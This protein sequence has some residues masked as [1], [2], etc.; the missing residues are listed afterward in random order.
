MKLFHFLLLTLSVSVTFLSHAQEAPY[1]EFVPNF[2]PDTNVV[3]EAEQ[4]VPVAPGLDT[5]LQA[6]YSPTPTTTF[7]ALS[8][9]GT[10]WPPDV[11]GAVGITNLMVM[12]NSETKITDRTGA[13]NLLQTSTFRWWTNSGSIQFVTDPRV[14]YDQYHG[15]WIAACVSDAELTNSA[16]MVAVSQNSDPSGGWYFR[17]ILMNTTFDE[18]HLVWADYTTLGFNK[19]WIAVGVNMATNWTTTVTNTDGSTNTFRT[20]SSVPQRTQAG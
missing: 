7:Q 9:N 1:I 11:H 13:T 18:M 12:H 14:V 10:F 6:F 4:P 19:T 8:D 20:N 2:E 3:V 16:V 15:R 17:K 5:S